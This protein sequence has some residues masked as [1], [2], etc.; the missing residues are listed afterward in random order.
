[1]KGKGKETAKAEPIQEGNENSIADLIL[2]ESTSPRGRSYVL[3]GA[4]TAVKGK[5]T[6]SADEATILAV[7]TLL[8]RANTILYKD[9][10]T[11]RGKEVPVEES[12]SGGKVKK[13]ANGKE[14]LKMGGLVRKA[15][16]SLQRVLSRKGR[17]GT[18]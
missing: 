18:P 1:M 15:S 5:G 9:C 12:G 2:E 14:N 11:I 17:S 6:G 13:A 4:E 3:E 7:P 8:T 16:I 10:M